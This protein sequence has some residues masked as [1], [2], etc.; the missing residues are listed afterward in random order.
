MD[1]WG[2]GRRHMGRT[3]A[4]ATLAGNVEHPAALAG[5]QFFKPHCV[6]V[7]VR[8]TPRDFIPVL[9]TLLLGANKPSGALRVLRGCGRA[10]MRRI[11]RY[12]F[13]LVRWWG[14]ERTLPP[15]TMPLSAT[16]PLHAT[17]DA[18]RPSPASPTPPRI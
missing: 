16:R 6:A 12:A 2:I 4:S 3:R 1:R 9:V 7:P 11:I 14:A 17:T 10:A 13:H 18:C 5:R 8:G 15:P